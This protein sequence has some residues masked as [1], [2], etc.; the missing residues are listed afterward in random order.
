MREGRPSLTATLVS[1]ARGV[2]KPPVDPVSRELL[3]PFLAGL[4]RA[5]SHAPAVANAVLF[6]LVDHQ[7]LRTRAIDAAVSDGVA[8]G[9][10]QLVILGAGL[11]A[12]AYRM[13]DLAAVTVYELD[14]RST[15]AHKQA[16]V[17]SRLPKAGAVHFVPVDFESGELGEALGRAGHD[18]EVATMWVWEGVVPYLKPEAVTTTLNVVGGCSAVGS[19]VAL[20]YA[21]K[22]LTVL[23]Q[24]V[25]EL[26]LPLF[27]LIGEPVFGRFEPDEMKQALGTAG[28]SVLH[29]DA[30]RDWARRF[31]HARTWSLLLE[32]RLVVACR[33]L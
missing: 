24:R 19:R 9:I 15:Q 30:P 18:K 32:E 14:H 10:R 13:T 33:R 11:D 1:F 4:Q 27:A 31:A 5:A 21:T 16:R 20:T 12:R 26:G 2:G 7:T 3:S 8:S 25:G 28:L 22:R 29:D 23:G 17:G 6:G